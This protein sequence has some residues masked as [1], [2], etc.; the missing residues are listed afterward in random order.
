[1]ELYLHSP[2]TYSWRGAYL[3]TGTTLPL[4]VCFLLPRTGLY[5]FCN[6]RPKSMS[7]PTI[8]SLH[9]KDGDINVVRNMI[10]YQ[11]TTRRHKPE[12]FRLEIENLFIYT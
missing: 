1:M 6:R 12:E 4:L 5:L 8:W 3:S 9:H 2:N 7:T 10:S 11:D